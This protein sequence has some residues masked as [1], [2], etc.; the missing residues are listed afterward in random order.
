MTESLAEDALY[1]DS[2]LFTPCLKFA[3]AE[4]SH[5]LRL[6]GFDMACGHT[7]SCPV[8][9]ISTSTSALEETFDQLN[10]K[11]KGPVGLSAGLPS[12]VEVL[13]TDLKSLPLD[14]KR[15]NTTI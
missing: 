5:K 1:Q 7:P 6:T 13:L 15:Y 2:P 3:C 4:C 14:V 12:K 8:A 10:E 11:G 9:H